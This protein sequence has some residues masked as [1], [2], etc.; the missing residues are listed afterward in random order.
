[1]QIPILLPKIFD[2]PFT[3]ES[4]KKVE[5]GGFQNIIWFL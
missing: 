4:E 5:V 3:Y 2:H 1:M